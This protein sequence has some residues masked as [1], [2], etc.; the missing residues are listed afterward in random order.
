ME[1]ERTAD[2][3]ERM[4][5]SEIDSRDF[6]Q[7]CRKC[8]FKKVV[9][10]RDFLGR[11]SY[12]HWISVCNCLECSQHIG[13]VGFGKVGSNCKGRVEI[14]FLTLTLP[15]QPLRIWF[16]GSPRD[17]TSSIG[18]RILAYKISGGS[19]DLES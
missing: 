6:G 4:W 10:S 15:T 16:F 3:L 1:S 18:G 11:P 12:Y 9:R 19:E 17:T 7:S 14:V 2:F 5:R 8:R 13:K